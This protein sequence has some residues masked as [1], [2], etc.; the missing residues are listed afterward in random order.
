MNLIF[1]GNYL[2]Y[3]TLFI[4]G[5][6]SKG[7][8]VLSTKIDQEMFIRKIATDMSHAI[9]PF[10]NPNKIVFT[11]DSR[12]WR[13]DVEIEEGGYKSNRERDESA[14]DW[15]SFYKCMNEFADILRRKGFIVSREERAEGDDLMYLW[16]DKFYNEGQDSVIITGDKD[17]TQCIKFNGSNFI[18]VYNPN[19]KSRKIVAP[20][21]FSS[22]LKTEEYDL[23]DASTFMNRS[24]DLIAEAISSIS[25]EEIDPDYLI[26]EKVITGDAGDAVPPVWTWENKG[27]TYRVTPSKAA[28]MYEIVNMTLPI[29]D[30][31]E[32]PNRAQEIANAIN[33]TCK[34]VAPTDAL[35]S[36]L[37]RNLKL[38]YLDTRIIPSDIQAAFKTSYE[39][40]K[41]NKEL[42]A[43]QYDMNHLLE[44]TR[45]ISGGRTFEADIFS[46]FKF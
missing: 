39:S 32:L 31:I 19:S 9:R 2:F 5:S 14:I 6:Y 37:E 4:F 23:F 38:V 44:G 41:E 36:R 34:Q 27:K 46:Q 30:V 25:V 7:S 40:A 45:F 11:I 13:K 26:F 21:G 10:G 17:L 18:V 1:D 12:S 16:A 22:W 29:I 24:K 28:R 42:S 43:N 20:K 33:A 8:R 15:D 35:K 3:K